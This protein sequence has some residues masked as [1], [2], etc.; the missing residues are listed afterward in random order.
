ML[1]L[2]F[3]PCILIGKAAMLGLQGIVGST[4]GAVSGG[5]MVGVVGAP[6]INVFKW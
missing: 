3:A 6:S 4:I 5:L 1:E 2:L